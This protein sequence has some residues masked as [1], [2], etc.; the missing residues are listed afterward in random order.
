MK[1]LHKCSETSDVVWFIDSCT[2]PKTGR[3]PRR[4]RIKNVEILSGSPEDGQDEEGAHQN[5]TGLMFGRPSW[6]GQIEMVWMGRGGMV[7]ILLEGCSKWC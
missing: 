6:R 7:N 4:D 3:R 2:D 5:S 1:G